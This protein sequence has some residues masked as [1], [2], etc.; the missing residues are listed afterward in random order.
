MA[1]V[2]LKIQTQQADNP[3]TRYPSAGLA[4]A[5]AD[6]RGRC[7]EY[8]HTAV[9]ASQHAYVRRMGKP[10]GPNSMTW[11]QERRKYDSAKLTL[12]NGMGVYATGSDRA[13]LALLQ[14]TIRDKQD[15]TQG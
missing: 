1:N 11:E 5:K 2:D 9:W 12:L 15:P 8:E 14:G 13:T 6:F 3:A 7:P 10:S 4:Q